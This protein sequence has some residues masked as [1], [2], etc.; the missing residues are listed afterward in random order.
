MCSPAPARGPCS[1][2]SGRRGPTLGLR[3]WGTGV[4]LL[5]TFSRWLRCAKGRAAPQDS[6]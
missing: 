2:L 4:S 1:Q 5:L 3:P 6:R